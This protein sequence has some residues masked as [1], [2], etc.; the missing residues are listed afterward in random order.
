MKDSYKTSRVIINTNDINK[1][2]VQNW[3]C[4]IY[5]CK[6]IFTHWQ[7]TDPNQRISEIDEDYDGND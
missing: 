5:D 2:T 3:D 7:P 4:T 1:V 6:E